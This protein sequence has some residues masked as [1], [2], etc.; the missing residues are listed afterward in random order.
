MDN[1]QEQLETL[2]DIR[3]LMERSSRFISLSG[4]SGV[5]AGVAAIAGIAVAYRYLGLE[6]T[7]PGYYNIMADESGAMKPGAFVFFVLDMGLV[8]IVSLLASTMLTMRK[9]RQQG[10]LVWDATAR[11]LLL[12]MLIPLTAGAIYCL[13]LL[14]HR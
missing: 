6:W 10:R 8:L 5:I 12:N 13:V 9:A 2:R 7:A 11:R 3:S 1:Q 14:N 4:L